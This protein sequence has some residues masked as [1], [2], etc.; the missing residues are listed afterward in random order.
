MLG[1]GFWE[2]KHATLRSK[3]WSRA[4]QKQ[5]VATP[6]LAWGRRANSLNLKKNLLVN[7]HS[8]LLDVKKKAGLSG[9][10]EYLSKRMARLHEKGSGLPAEYRDVDLREFREGEAKLGASGASPKRPRR[11]SAAGEI[12]KNFF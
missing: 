6:A 8:P 9:F 3:L 7:V 10:F 12:K 2:E 5:V 4:L 1:H 11:K